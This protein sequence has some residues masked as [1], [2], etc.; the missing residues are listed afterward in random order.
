M[1]FRGKQRRIQQNVKKRQLKIRNR[2]NPI[3]VRESST[4]DSRIRIL[5]KSIF[6]NW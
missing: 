2:F 4:W 6:R 5:F 1:G 3:K